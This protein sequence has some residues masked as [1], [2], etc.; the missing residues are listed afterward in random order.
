MK[1]NIREKTLERLKK[2]QKYIIWQD[3]FFNIQFN[4]QGASVDI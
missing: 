3:K 2:V 4:F 1:I